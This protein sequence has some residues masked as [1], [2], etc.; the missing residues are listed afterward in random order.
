MFPFTE[1]PTSVVVL[2]AV[3]QQLS[4]V[5]GPLEESNDLILTCKAYGGYNQLFKKTDGDVHCQSFRLRRMLLNVQVILN[6]G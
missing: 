4:I 2:D 3:L 1:P 5:A 6:L